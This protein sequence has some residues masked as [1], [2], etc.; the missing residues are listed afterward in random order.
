MLIA[1]TERLTRLDEARECR[2]EALTA[3]ANTVKKEKGLGSTSVGTR[4]N[5][6]LAATSEMVRPNVRLDQGT[7]DGCA[8]RT[9]ARM[10]PCR[11]SCQGSP[12]CAV[13]RKVPRKVGNDLQTIDH[14][15]VRRSW[16]CPMLALEFGNVIDVWV[17][18]ADTEDTANRPH[19]SVDDGRKENHVRPG[20]RVPDPEPSNPCDRPREIQQQPALTSR[21]TGFRYTNVVQFVTE[22]Q[23]SQRHG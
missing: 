13:H 18:S 5:G 4:C 22:A 23:K 20:N 11:R 15:G 21:S 6:E 12:S 2:I 8:T 19:A 14:I 17:H 7:K 3:V 10:C 9:G 16:R 1:G